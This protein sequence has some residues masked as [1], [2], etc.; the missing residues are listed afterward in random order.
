MAI[1][2]TNL[3]QREGTDATFVLRERNTTT[4][5]SVWA[6]ELARTSEVRS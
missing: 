4:L 1:C 6:V 2:Y 5:V 3:K